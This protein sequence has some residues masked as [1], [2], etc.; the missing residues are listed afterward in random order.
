MTGK[1]IAYDSRVTIVVRPDTQGI[2]PGA[3]LTRANQKI[4]DRANI[5]ITVR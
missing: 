4:L 2:L 1:I 5:Q 3:L